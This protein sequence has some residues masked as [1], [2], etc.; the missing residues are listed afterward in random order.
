MSLDDFKALPQK[1]KL[2]CLFENQVETLTTIRGY[3]LY[4]KITSIIG[5]ALAT[6]MSILF[7]FVIN[8]KRS[9]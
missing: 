1:K 8:I 3:K 5:T 7:Y 2:N 9:L 6:G 4:Y